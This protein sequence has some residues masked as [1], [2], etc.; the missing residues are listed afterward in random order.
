M[1]TDMCEQ[2]RIVMMSGEQVL[3][4][5]GIKQYLSCLDQDFQINVTSQLN[6]IL[7]GESILIE[8]LN[9]ELK[10]I[11]EAHPGQNYPQ[12]VSGITDALERTFKPATS[13]NETYY[14]DHYLR[15]TNLTNNVKE[16][17]LKLPYC[18]YLN[19]W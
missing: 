8:Q 4:S 11:S 12:N 16:R 5:G 10:G 2:M 1:F 7:V 18:H 15:L 17:L 6:N 3:N 19:H 14:R 13:S 9:F